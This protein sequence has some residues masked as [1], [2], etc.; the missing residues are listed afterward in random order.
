MDIAARQKVIKEMENRGYSVTDESGVL[1]FLGKF[2]RIDD[3]MADIKKNLESLDFQGSWGTRGYPKG[4]KPSARP[5]EPVAEK[6]AEDPDDDLL[7]E[8]AEEAVGV[9]ANNS[10][11]DMHAGLSDDL[12]SD[13]T[14]DDSDDGMPSFSLDADPDSFTQLSFDGLF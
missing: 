9:S 6:P 11:D 2:D 8:S 14:A 13:D 12:L 3:S 1:M 4:Y 5:V 10:V 7:E